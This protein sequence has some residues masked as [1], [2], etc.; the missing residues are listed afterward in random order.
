MQEPVLV[1]NITVRIRLVSWTYVE[2]GEPDEAR[3]VLAK[4]KEAATGVETF[5]RNGEHQSNDRVKRF[6]NAG[7]GD[8][9][10]GLHLE[11]PPA[12]KQQR[13]RGSGGGSRGF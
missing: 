3:R 6:S 1:R 8:E 4:A 7:S 2:V 12:P 5:V 9:W 13:L 11:T 10:Y